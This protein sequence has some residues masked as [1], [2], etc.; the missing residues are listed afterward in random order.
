MK[1]AY[2]AIG[3]SDRAIRASDAD[4]ESVVAILR[5][6]YAAGRLTLEEFDERTTAAFSGRTWGALSELTKDLPQDPKLGADLR[7]ADAPGSDRAAGRTPD[8]G[9]RWWRI[10]PLLPI[11]A[12]WLVVALSAQMPD[13]VFPVIIA[14]LLLLRCTVSPR[15]ERR[16]A[17]RSRSDDHFPQSAARPEPRPGRDGRAR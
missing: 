15:P 14:L 10:L 9:E 3:A 4:R 13:S 5:D 16:D 17:L 1:T 12:V 11:A 2:G 6:A 8:A 7:R